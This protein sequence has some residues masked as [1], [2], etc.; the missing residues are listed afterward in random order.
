MLKITNHTALQFSFHLILIFM[1][2]TIDS[3]VGDMKAVKGIWP[4]VL[5]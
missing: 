5:Q 1:V 3:K 2:V 4:A